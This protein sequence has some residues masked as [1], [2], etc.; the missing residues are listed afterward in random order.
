MRQGKA[1]VNFNAQHSPMGAFMSFTCGHFNAPGGIGVEIGKPAGQNIYVGVKDGDRASA[2]PL[3]CLP[4]YR[5][6]ATGAGAADFLVEQAGPAEQNV[7]PNVVAFAD[8]TIKRQYDWATDRWIADELEFAI[9]TPFAGIPDP[10]RSTPEDM[11]DALLPAICAELVID[12]SHG[13]QTRT[14]VFA[15]QFDAPGT[16]AIEIGMPGAKGFAW[17]GKYGFA[18]VLDADDDLLALQRW[19]VAEAIRDANPVHQLGTCAGVAFE[20][21]AGEIRRLRIA[22]GCYLDGIVTTRLQGRYLYTRYFSSL[23]DVLGCALDEDHFCERHS[24]AWE[25]DRELRASGLSEAQQFVIAHATRSYYGSTQLLDV[26]GE[27]FWNVN[28]GEYCMMN[29]LDLSVDHVFW[30]L[31]QNP[32]LVRNLLD[33][34]VRHYSYVDDRGTSFSHDMG[35]HNNF[36]PQGSSSYELP[37]LKGCFS[38]MT[39]EQLCNWILTASCYVAKTN[40][41]DWLNHNWHVIDACAQSLRARANPRTG[42]MLHDS[43]RCEGGWE[44]TTYDSLDE[45]LGQARANAYLAMKCW[46]SWIAVEML[47]QM[48]EQSASRS[49]KPQSVSQAEPQSATLGGLAD[50]IAQTLIL[51]ARSDGAIPAVLEADNPGHQSRI[52]PIIEALIYPAYWS[53]CGQNFDCVKQALQGPLIAALRR[54]TLAL[55]DDPEHRNAFADGGVKLSSSSDNSWMSKIAIF[56]YVARD[57][58]RIALDPAADAAHVRW[59]IEGSAHWACSDQFVKGIAKGSRYYPRIIT[60]A[61]WMSESREP[62]VQVTVAPAA[63]R[64]PQAAPAATQP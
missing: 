43:S 52:L 44:I 56:Q 27:P 33:N 40:D 54:H 35:A 28:E 22:I 6:R 4:F 26:G 2:A 14:A 61:L 13:T 36:S 60:A 29:T 55:L 5:A 24:V 51:S 8:E 38:F 37:R 25:L 53:R 41:L 20:I 31:D 45:S 34:F 19:D 58:L 62:A 30:E 49:A 39:Q 12:N 46:A 18:A 23:A 21:P 15:I 16:H 7:L 9:F 64:A 57:V 1:N 42:V 59:Q 3:K 17:R 47:D 32:W 50:R 48:R 63:Q 10:T 11:R